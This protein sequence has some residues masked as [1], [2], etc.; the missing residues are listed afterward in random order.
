MYLKFKNLARGARKFY[1]MVPS[2]IIYIP[3]YACHE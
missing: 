2:Q 1:N 3:Y